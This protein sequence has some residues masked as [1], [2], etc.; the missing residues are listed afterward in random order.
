[1]AHTKAAGSAKRTVDVAGKRLGLKKFAGEYVKPGNII[2]RQHG[3]KFHAGVGTMLGRDYTVFAVNE[4]FVSF[5]K[6]T[7][8]KRTQ[9]LVDVLPTR[10]ELSSNK[11]IVSGT[12]AVDNK[13]QK[14]LSVAAQAKADVKAET[15][16]TEAK[17][18]KAAVKAKS[19][20]KKKAAAKKQ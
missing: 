19:P 13:M 11:K 4:G 20:A 6:M 2:V 18:P 10:D 16:K 15:A 9:N 3:S 14:S 5:R 7:G 17:A 8:H 1:M 12:A